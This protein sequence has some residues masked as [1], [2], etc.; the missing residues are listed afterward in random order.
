MKKRCDVNCSGK[1]GAR[2]E[3]DRFIEIRRR[4]K[5]SRQTNSYRLSRRSTGSLQISW[6]CMKRSVRRVTGGARFSS[7]RSTTRLS[8]ADTF[9]QCSSPQS[10]PRATSGAAVS[11]R[12]TSS[13]ADRTSCKPTLDLLQLDAVR[14]N[15]LVGG[16]RQDQVGRPQGSRKLTTA[17]QAG[18]ARR[19][20]SIQTSGRIRQTAT[21]METER[22]PPHHPQ[23]RAQSPSKL[24]RGGKHCPVCLAKLSLNAKR[25][26]VRLDC[27]GCRAHPQNDKVCIRCGAKRI[28]QG[29]AGVACQACGA[30]GE[31]SEIVAGRAARAG[32]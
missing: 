21:S 7:W 24:R 2:L 10:T 14:R 6:L 15:P 9:G 17:I 20:G 19:R 28:W 25:T 12:S 1:P 18:A 4:E 30:N 26:R 16:W 8:G 11:R 22:E 13:T 3:R 31:A 32:A 23:N 29:P 5:L 27:L